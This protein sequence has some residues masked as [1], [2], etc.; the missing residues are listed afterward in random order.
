[1]LNYRIYKV[2]YNFLHYFKNKKIHSLESFLYFWLLYLKYAI[3]LHVIIL[4]GQTD[5]IG[6]FI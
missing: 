5:I 6:D 2:I 1:M 3:H 4:K